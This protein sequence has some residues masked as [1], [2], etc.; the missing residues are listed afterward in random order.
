MPFSVF[1][2]NQFDQESKDSQNKDNFFGDRNL[3]QVKYK[4]LE[5]DQ[6]WQDRLVN[7]IYD[8]E[9]GLLSFFISNKYGTKK[10]A[11][12][13]PADSFLPNTQQTK[14]SGSIDED[15]QSQVSSNTLRNYE[16]QKQ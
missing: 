2:Q 8:D 12:Y 4:Q 11:R 15:F 6:E 16:Y 1:K 9:G 13:T 10:A 7:E 14:H 5:I 3:L